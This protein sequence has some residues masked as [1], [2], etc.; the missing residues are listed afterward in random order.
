MKT[1][2]VTENPIR[3]KIN[4]EN[5]I[6]LWKMVRKGEC[7]GKHILL[8]HG[9][10][11]N[12][13]VLG[14][15]SEYLV[16]HGFTCWIFEWRNHGASSKS[17]DKFNF[18][19]I[20]VEDFKLVFQYLFEVERLS[21]IDC[22][23]HSGGGICLTIALLTHAEYQRKINSISMFACQAFGAADSAVNHLK[24]RGGKFVS[25]LLG[26]IPATLIGREE[27][28][29]Y[30]TMKQWF[31]WNITGEFRGADGTDYQ[32]RMKEID[33]PILSIFC[34]GDTFIAPPSGCEAFLNAF[35]RPQNKSLYA[36]MEEGYAEDY[37]HGRILHSRNAAKEIYP[38]VLSWIER[39]GRRSIS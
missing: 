9:T 3:I 13:K 20:G 10:F 14:G 39:H 6:A 16:S 19:T 15:I 33:I 38:K 11:S 7:S 18:E 31:D 1:E 30:D 25:W 12:R 17:N 5:H 29:S 21:N 24:I 26:R 35:D 22:I 32:C 4:D 23:T 36:S 27:D 8:T 2:G 34:Q 37:D 28:E